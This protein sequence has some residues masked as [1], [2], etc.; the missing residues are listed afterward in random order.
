[1]G[2]TSYSKIIFGILAILVIIFSIIGTTAILI[3]VLNQKQAINHLVPGVGNNTIVVNAGTSPGSIGTHKNGSTWVNFIDTANVVNT[4]DGG[5]N[6]LPRLTDTGILVGEYTTSF[7]IDEKGRIISALNTDI[8]LIETINGIYPSPSGEF[9][10]TGGVNTNVNPIDGTSFSVG[11][12]NAI[13]VQNLT[14][15]GNTY[16]DSITSCAVPL[17]SECID[18]SGLN[19]DAGSG[20]LSSCLPSD[21]TFNNLHVESMS[22]MSDELQIDLGNQDN[23]AVDILIISGN[24]TMDSTSSITCSNG[25]IP[26]DCFLIENTHCNNAISATCIP[27]SDVF[28]HLNVTD[29]MMFNGTVTCL[30]DPIHPSCVDYNNKSCTLALDDSC[31]PP[32]L[33]SINGVVSETLALT[34]S[35]YVSI[36]TN[37]N[38]IQIDTNAELNTAVNVGT[39]GH[40]VYSGLKR[41]EVLKFHA[42]GSSNSIGSALNT[43]NNTVE[44][45]VQPSGVVP[46]YYTAPTITTDAKGR[47]TAATSFDKAVTASNVGT[48][49]I[50]LYKGTTS[51]SFEFKNVASSTLNITLDESNNNILLDLPP[52]GVVSGAYGDAD[53]VLI[54]T[55]LQNGLLSAH[56]RTQVTRKMAPFIVSARVD[57][58]LV[59]G[60]N[61]TFT[62]EVYMN[63]FPPTAWDG[64]LLT[65]EEDANYFIQLA[66]AHSSTSGTSQTVV[67]MRNGIDA[68]P[69]YAGQRYSRSGETFFMVLPLT[70]GETISFYLHTKETND[71]FYLK[72]YC[73]DC[74]R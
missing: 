30:G 10:V 39:E 24:I 17:D 31:I 69:I 25:P 51:T 2:R 3:N 26:H 8:P 14:I 28:S 11:L 60:T 68:S 20:F 33:K 27:P 36:N 71:S 65:I 29:T 47:I 73:L 16:L 21:I 1:M 41:E 12:K 63:T 52:T 44:Y 53:N 15:S 49:G 67:L 59:Q 66:G 43:A 9:G 37:M 74:Q 61:I 13:I 72:I 42:L 23:L 56:A 7:A 32:L 45:F 70:I 22:V 48:S 18:I 38:G 55:V 62:Q 54:P 64:T 19:C 4:L 57:T 58:G 50:P 35:G 34:S 6:I 40:G 5:S 46:G